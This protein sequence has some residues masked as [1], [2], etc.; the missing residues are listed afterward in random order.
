MAV[1]LAGEPTAPD[2]LV[3]IMLHD[4]QGLI[5]LN[6]A[7][8][9]ENRKDASL[10]PAFHTALQDKYARIQIM[11]VGRDNVF[12]VYPV[13]EEARRALAL[14]GEQP[15]GTVTEVKRWYASEAEMLSWLLT[16]KEPQVCLTVVRLLAALDREGTAYLRSFLDENRAEE[17]LKAA[18]EVAEKAL[19]GQGATG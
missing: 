1:A 3:E 16:D 19:S 18:V 8:A 5:R 6:A 11:D 14:L 17:S 15:P 7:L 13:R 2:E 12:K 4:P 9:L 10:K